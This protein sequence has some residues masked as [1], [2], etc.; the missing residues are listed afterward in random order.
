MTTPAEIAAEAVDASYAVWGVAATYTPP[1]GGSAVSCLVIKD[2]RDRHAS[3]PRGQ[4]V[5]KG[6]TLAVRRSEIA[7]PRKGGT[8][9]LTATAESLTVQGDPVTREADPERLEW[10]C[11][12]T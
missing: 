10:V 7:L 9:D 11:T 3:A 1:G 4:P 5:M 6:T 12:V 2:A 8:F